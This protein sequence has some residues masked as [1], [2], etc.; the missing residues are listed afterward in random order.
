[1]GTVGFMNPIEIPAGSTLTVQL[2]DTSL[3]D[4]A[5]KVLGETV[6]TDFSTIPIPFTVSYDPTAIDTQ[7]TYSI[8]ARI[9]DGAGNLIFINTTAYNVITNGNPSVIEVIVEPV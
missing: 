9:T 7:F 4:V 6:I 1:M 3:Q 2:Q 8:S 5:A